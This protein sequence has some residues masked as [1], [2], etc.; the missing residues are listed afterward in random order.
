MPFEL[1]LVVFHIFLRYTMF[2]AVVTSLVTTIYSYKAY[3]AWCRD[4]QIYSGVLCMYCLCVN[5]RQL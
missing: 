5:C 4:S 1:Y 3:T 2:G